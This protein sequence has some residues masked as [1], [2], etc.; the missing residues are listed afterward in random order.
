MENNENKYL[1]LDKHGE[2]VVS[3]S[4]WVITLLVCFIPLVNII[5]LLVWAFGGGANPNKANFAKAALIFVVI[6][7][8]LM[9]FFMGRYMS[10]FKEM[11]FY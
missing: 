9:T 6:Y 11:I 3:L 7:F 5:M 8:L 2:P 1:D 4:E 10:T